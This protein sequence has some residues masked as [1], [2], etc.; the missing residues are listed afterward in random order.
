M[1]KATYIE[2]APHHLE[3]IYQLLVQGTHFR[4]HQLVMDRKPRPQDVNLK[5]QI[6]EPTNLVNCQVSIN[7]SKTYLD[8]A[9]LPN[10]FNSTT[11]Y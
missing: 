11:T 5:Q 6:F 1:K 9:V 3:L 4:V 7:Y 2:T 10:C 8:T